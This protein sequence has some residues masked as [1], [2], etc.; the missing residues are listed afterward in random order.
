LLTVNVANNYA[1]TALHSFATH[2]ILIKSTWKQSIFRAL[3]C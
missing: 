1:V 2:S 3:H